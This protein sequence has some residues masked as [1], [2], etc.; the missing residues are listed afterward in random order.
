VP[1]PHPGWKWEFP[2]AIRGGE[3]TGRPLGSA[4]FVAEPEALTGRTLA[5]QGPSTYGARSGAE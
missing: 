5:S 3:R 2:A 1:T 4:D